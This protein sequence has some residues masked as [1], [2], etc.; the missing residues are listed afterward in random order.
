[1]GWVIGELLTNALKFTPSNGVV[2]I[3]AEDNQGLVHV[4][5]KDTGIGI[6]NKRLEEI[7]MPFHQLD[8]STTRHYGGTGLGLAL[9]QRIVEAH[10]SQVK[11][12]SEVGNGSC[13]EFSLPAIS[14]AI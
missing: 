6:A 3:Q 14:T 13:F 5:V 9:L 11:V 4:S 1:M 12:T 2:Q 7:F 10:G 8:S